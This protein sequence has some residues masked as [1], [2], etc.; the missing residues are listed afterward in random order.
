MS[1][2]IAKAESVDT[3]IIDFPLLLSGA[4]RQTVLIMPHEQELT[5][6]PS[7]LEAVSITYVRSHQVIPEQHSRQLILSEE[8]N[9]IKFKLINPNA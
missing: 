9:T 7:T 8:G 1:L 5:I 6:N 3:F 4:T 2:V